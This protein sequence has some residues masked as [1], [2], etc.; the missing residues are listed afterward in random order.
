MSKNLILVVK[1]RVV[2]DRADAHKLPS[3]MLGEEALG[4]IS[5]FFDKTTQGGTNRISYDKPSSFI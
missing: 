4:I 2:G 3:S 5:L 1:K